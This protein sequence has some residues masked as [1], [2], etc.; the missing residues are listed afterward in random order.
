VAGAGPSRF[1]LALRDRL[2]AWVQVRCGLEPKT[3]AALAVVLVAA[4]VFAAQHFWAGRPQA[5]RADPG[6]LHA[7]HDRPLMPGPELREVYRLAA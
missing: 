4:A 1:G 7:M 5:V 6:E 3:L 2:P